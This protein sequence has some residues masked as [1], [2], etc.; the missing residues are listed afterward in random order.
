MKELSI[1]M[2]KIKGQETNND[3]KEDGINETRNK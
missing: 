2:N 1:E 3:T